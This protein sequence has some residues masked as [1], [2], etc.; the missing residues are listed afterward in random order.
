[1]QLQIRID[2]IFGGQ[3]PLTYFGKTGQFKNSLALDPD[4]EATTGDNRASGF[5]V[6]VPSAKLSTSNG[7]GIDDEPLWMNTNPK[8]DDVY[9]YDRAGKVYTVILA[10]KLISDLNAG[11]ALTASTGN[12]SAYYD[13][14]QYFIKNTNVCRYGPLNGSR[15][16]N[17]TY[18]GTTLSMTALSNGVT[19]PA[20]K[21]G[22][23]RYPNHVCHV[24]V[25][26]KLYICDIPSSGQKNGS[27]VVHY[28]RTK[29]DT[30]EG[31]TNN[32]STWNALD[33]GFGI[34]P[35][36]LESY[37][38]DLVISGYEGNTT[39]GNTRG[40]RAKIYFWDT[41]SASFNKEVELP[42]P[43]CSALL[44]V[45]GILYT[46]SGNPGDLGVRVCRFA[47]GYTFE[48]VAYLEDSQLPYAGA[49]DHL[50][51]RVLFGGF[52]SS[53]G[54]YACLYALGSKIG[55][56]S[57]GIFNV[58]RSS[59]STS[60]GI[61]VTCVL[62]PENTDVINP[63]YLIGWR[64]AGGTSDFGIDQNATTYG[65]AE[66]QSAIYRIGK[67]FEITKIKIPLGQAVG[68][69]MTVAVKVAVDNESTTT[70]VA[71][72][73]STNFSES[74]RFVTLHP[75]IL[76][77]HDFFIQFSWSGTSLLSIGLPIEIEVDEI[78]D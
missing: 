32:G 59:S 21:I 64:D 26:D 49:V 51:S 4:L 22:T 34:F 31:D 40:K 10:N 48:E 57:N 29:R 14:Y 27:G 36:D 6:P 76:G 41:I 62:V 71:T 17:Q 67:E 7:T 75:S 47:G 33:L 65:V 56:I 63:I 19:Y 3:S 69:N 25:D 53:M 2:N 54:N 8:D 72:I 77:K 11:V 60:T 74:E 13:N 52:S 35:M 55:K 12:G 5:L 30:A 42:D 50:M 58:M 70:T 39:S 16:F 28:I 23:S 73:N 61:N 18:W 20:P 44:N 38:T 45:N 43:L 15:T 68:T 66:F 46:F 1:M 9:V 24:H 37:G 78:S